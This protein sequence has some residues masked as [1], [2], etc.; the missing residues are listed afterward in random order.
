MKKY[1]V[2]VVETWERI[3]EVEANDEEDARQELIEMLDADDIQFYDNTKSDKFKL[4]DTAEM[5]EWSVEEVK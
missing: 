1:R 4:I 2:T 3:V 5:K